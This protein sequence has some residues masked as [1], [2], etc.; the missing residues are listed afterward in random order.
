MDLSTLYGNK[1]PSNISNG[2]KK[3]FKHFAKKFRYDPEHF[4]ILK[5]YDMG[6]GYEDFGIKTVL[7]SFFSEGGSDISSEKSILL[8]TIRMGFGHCR[9]AIALASAA[10]ALGYT[11]Y[12]IDLLSFPD[13]AASKTIRYLEN[14][15]NVGSRFSQKSKLFNK[16]VWDYMTADAGRRL[17]RTVEERE[18]SKIFAPVFK[19][20]PK[21]IPILATHAWV[22]H[23]AVS[24]RMKNIVTV[25]PDNYPLAFYIVPNTVHAVQSPSAYMGYRT[26][27]SMGKKIRLDYCMPENEIIEAG[28]F[29]D[30]EIVS[31]IEN[32]CNLRLKRIRNGETRRFLLTMGGAGAQVLRFADIIK[33]CKNYINDEKVSFFVNM[34]DHKGR[35]KEL[36]KHFIKDG[37]PFTMHTDWN[38]TRDF[39]NQN[40][41]SK[42]KG[43]HVFLHDNFYAAVYTT[44]LLMRISDVMI[45]KP[46]ELAFYPVPKLFIEHV[47]KH[48]AWGAYRGSEIGDGTIETSSH[49]NLH[50][51]LRLLIEENDLLE[52]Y[53]RHIIQN[54]ANGI[55]DG[56]YNAVKAAIALKDKNKKS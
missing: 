11:P 12:W 4:P 8:G 6:S 53:C 23:G 24:A 52:L 30:H 56:A 50:R 13:N 36:E 14:W 44:N 45:T 51:T 1:I 33:N 15:Y 38:Q 10:K 17:S 47:G 27:M 41:D 34:G 2:A 7:D 16:Y 42:M 48:E 32:D 31:N 18:L 49:S 22:G 3:Q 43:I 54:K 46:S 21:D 19:T 9:I 55:Y 40:R 35:W 39:V 29:V 26:L 5:A 20:V 25:V 28:H 37:I